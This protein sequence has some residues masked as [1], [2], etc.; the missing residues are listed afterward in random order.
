[1][2]VLEK[3]SRAIGKDYGITLTFSGSKAYTDCKH[4]NIPYVPPELLTPENEA[5]LRGYCD[6]EIA[7]VLF[8]SA[9]MITERWFIDAPKMVQMMTGIIEDIR[10]ESLMSSKY[11]GARVNM[12]RLSQL[13]SL[14][15]DMKHP[16]GKLLIEGRRQC[17]NYIFEGVDDVANDLKAMFGG[18]VF[19]LISAT[20]SSLDSYKL[21]VELLKK[22][23]ESEPPPPEA[24][25]DGKPKDGKPKDGKPK[26]GKPKDG[27]PKD[28]K[29]E[30]PE[31][32]SEFRDAEE[33]T[34]RSDSVGEDACDPEDDGDGSESDGE[35]DGEGSGESDDGDPE[36]D[37]DDGDGDG[38]EGECE[39]EGEGDGSESDGEGDGEESDSGGTAG[40]SAESDG[41]DEGSGDD[42]DGSTGEPGDPSDEAHEE[43]AGGNAY[44]DSMGV[45]EA[46]LKACDTPFT[47][48][49]EDVMA[50]LSK[51]HRDS[52]KSGTYMP[53]STSY[54]ILTPAK[55]GNMREYDLLKSG[56]GNF[57]A[58]RAKVSTM[59]SARTAGHWMLGKDNGRIN[60]RALA[61]IVADRKDLFK[62]KWVCDDVDTAIT[63]LIDLSGSM[64]SNKKLPTA[65]ATAVLFSELLYATKVKFEILGFTT[66]AYIPGASGGHSDGIR[67]SRIEKLMTVIFKEYNEAF[68]AKIKRRLAGW[69]N[70]DTANN[71]DGESV[72]IAFKRI[73]ERKEKR[74]ILFVL[75]DGQPCSSGDDHAGRRHLK[76]VCKDIENKSPVELIGIGYMN[77]GVNDYYSKTI[78]INDPTNLPARMTSEL[79]KILHVK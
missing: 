22:K 49:L 68:G 20:K 38:E 41:D 36:D 73:M 19:E 29:T 15:T 50:M 64:N 60:N 31:D 39:G 62:Q 24:P 42:S 17:C 13:M 59:F 30:K 77:P 9:K 51:L 57:S 71:C 21:A 69:K 40:M 54:D 8:S 48:P 26:D 7:H 44:S 1:M 14:E 32:D 28:G 74:K 35:G 10:V 76:N 52:A 79:K 78:L 46:G 75:S 72:M 37:G 18:N 25:K 47:D 23:E 67:Y 16:F 3:V 58:M 63:F 11:A 34:E 2:E 4:I 70:I 43:S 5:K 56:L 61:G 55:E 6:H 53:F 66:D 33:R 27:K 65:M 12:Q 45:N